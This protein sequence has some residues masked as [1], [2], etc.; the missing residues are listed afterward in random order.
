[1]ACGSEGCALPLV[2]A[3]PD[4]QSGKFMKI[5][6]REPDGQNLPLPNPDVMNDIFNALGAADP[7]QY[8]F[9]HY[10]VQYEYGV[11]ILDAAAQQRIID[12]IK[13]T[14]G[15]DDI[16]DNIPLFRIHYLDFIRVHR[17]VNAFLEDVTA[18][19]AQGVTFSRPKV[20]EEHYAK[21]GRRQNPL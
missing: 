14:A 13:Q 2:V 9:L 21:H 4:D 3:F 6:L 7:D 12:H 11:P 19:T 18:G 17:F 10:A 15:D 5:F 1:M 8:H 16:T 20:Y